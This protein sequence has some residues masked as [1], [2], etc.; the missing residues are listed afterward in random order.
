MLTMAIF[1]VFVL[2]LSSPTLPYFVRVFRIGLTYPALKS[3]VGN[4]CL[5]PI[6]NM[7]VA[8]T[9]DIQAQGWIRQTQRQISNESRLRSA[10]QNKIFLFF[11]RNDW[12]TVKNLECPPACF[13]FLTWKSLSQMYSLITSANLWN[14]G[15]E[16]WH[17]LG[18]KKKINRICFYLWGAQICGRNT[19]IYR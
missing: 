11:Y 12:L 5:L 19:Y 1:F 13:F 9:K 16:L 17:T 10:E 2:I 7:V 18:T 6:K 4:V 8:K 15:Q 3:T 14:C